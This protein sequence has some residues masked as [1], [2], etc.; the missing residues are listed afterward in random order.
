MTRRGERRGIAG[1]RAAAAGMAGMAAALLAA[2][3]AAAQ[4]NGLEYAVV[5]GVS[6]PDALD[7]LVGD[8]ERGRALFLEDKRADCAACHK[9]SGVTGPDAGKDPDA[10]PALDAVG[11]RLS[12]GALRLWIV[13]PAARVADSAMPAYYSL[14]AG[15]EPDAPPREEPL[16]TAQEIEDLVLFL[17]RLG[18]DG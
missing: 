6:I 18:R 11:L 14:T 12:Q 7:G 9:I 3:P 8:P 15:R 17:D 1:C 4:D 16:L 5:D 2:A 10:G 13:N